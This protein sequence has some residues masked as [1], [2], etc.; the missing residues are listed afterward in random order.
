MVNENSDSLE[1]AGST[2]KRGEVK[3]LEIKVARLYDFTEMSIPV[4]VIRGKK[5][6]PRLFVTAALHG[7]E[8]N[9]VEIIKRLL[10]KK[11]LKKIRGDLLVI[12][13]V[14]IFGFNTQSRYLPDR[15]DLNRSFPGNPKGSQAARLANILFEE[16]VK[17]CTHGID[18]HT[19]SNHRENFP[20]IRAC[21]SD[22]RARKLVKAFEAPVILNSDLLDGSLRAVAKNGKEPLNLRF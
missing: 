2:I 7:D 18:L 16:I 10:Q 19:G 12:P 4:K 20:Q 3:Q 15:R 11:I 13:I 21:V 17:K 5:P 8:I 6:G 1:I 14:N 9:G 22:P